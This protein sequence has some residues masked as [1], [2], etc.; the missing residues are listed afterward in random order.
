MTLFPTSAP[1]DEPTMT[2]PKEKPRTVARKPSSAPAPAALDSFLEGAQDAP[3]KV[4]GASRE[5]REKKVSTPLIL[6]PSLKR[7]M[8]THIESL[9]T[10]T[11]RSIWICEAI[12]EK[13][14]RDSGK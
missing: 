3:G 4:S 11:S 9:R 1:M 6:P 12:K 5:K 14:D 7:E 13:L 2:S 8:E 10:G